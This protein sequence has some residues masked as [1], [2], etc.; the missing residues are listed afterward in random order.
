MNSIVF[1]RLG[2]QILFPYFLEHIDTSLVAI[3]AVLLARAIAIY[4]FS[5]V[6]G[7][8]TRDPIPWP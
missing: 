3:L 6:S 7:W 1:L 4:G 8:I 5:A 2:D